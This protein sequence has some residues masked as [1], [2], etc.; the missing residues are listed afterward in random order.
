MSD[1]ASELTLEDKIPVPFL[2]PDIGDWVFALFWH[3][4]PM[5]G[6]DKNG[7][8]D[9]VPGRVISVG[10]TVCYEVSCTTPPAFGGD[11]VTFDRSP[12]RFAAP[13]R[14]FKST[15][16]AKKYALKLTPPVS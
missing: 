9:T 16:D 12:I 11:D 8:W 14:V 6:N 10:K 7:Y 15:E 4:Y 2:D 1:P 3:P 13:D 5:P